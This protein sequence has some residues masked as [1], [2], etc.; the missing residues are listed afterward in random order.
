MPITQP[1]PAP[2]TRAAT[3]PGRVVKTVPPGM[4]AMAIQLDGP[5]GPASN[6]MEIPAMCV[7]VAV[8]SLMVK[9]INTA[10]LVPLE[11]MWQYLV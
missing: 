1:C 11:P 4:V 6:Q 5:A 9:S 8:P 10:P 2:A 3:K 7:G